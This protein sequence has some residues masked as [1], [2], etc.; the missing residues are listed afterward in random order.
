M[1]YEMSDTTMLKLSKVKGN[2]VC[3]NVVLE[4]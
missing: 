1:A 4:M 2:F 3:E